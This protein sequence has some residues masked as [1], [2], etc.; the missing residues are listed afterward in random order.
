MFIFYFQMEQDC[1]NWMAYKLFRT[2]VKMKKDVVPRRNLD[3]NPDVSR[4]FSQLPRS[5]EKRKRSNIEEYEIKKQQLYP[6]RLELET[7]SPQLT[8]IEPQA[9]SDSFSDEPGTSGLQKQFAHKKIQAN[10]KTF[11]SSVRSIGVNTRKFK[12]QSVLPF[13]VTVTK[14]CFLPST[15]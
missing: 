10:I 11:G 13:Q 3:G 7:V 12:S 2:Q 14:K 6:N 1:E 8:L 4:D 15:S 9:E 5:A